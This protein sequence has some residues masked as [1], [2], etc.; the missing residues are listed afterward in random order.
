MKTLLEAKNVSKSFGKLTAVKNIS[1][2]VFTGEI[3][4]IAG[5][6]GAGKTTLLNLISGHYKPDFGSI[7][8][9]G[10]YIHGLRPYQIAHL[11]ITRTFQTPVI[12]ESLSVLENVLIG[13]MFGKH[14]SL[15]HILRKNTQQ[16]AIQSARE[17]LDFVG[18][19]EKETYP[20]KN[21]SLAD[22]KLLM[23]AMGIA[24]GPEL[25]LLDEPVGGLSAQE[26]EQVT[27]VI[28]LLN[29]KGIT[30]IIIEHVMRT[31]MNLSHRVM[32]MHYGEKI[33]EG[34]PKEVA[35]DEKV[36]EVYLGK[37]IME[38]I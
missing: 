35:R 4:G 17:A 27:Q 8:F 1:F 25:F 5:P 11:G 6:N 3:F 19:K 21:L 9:K 36:I 12:F 30:I 37:E 26:I 23:I 15:G 13:S 16:T 32:I 24:T 34:T 29:E 20:L 38:K 33:A 22:R 28:K 2:T 31:L 7:I 14:N 10:I 18:L